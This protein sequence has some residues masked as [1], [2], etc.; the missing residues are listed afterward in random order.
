MFLIKFL[1]VYTTDSQIYPLL[2]NFRLGKERF[3]SYLGRKIPKY[4]SDEDT[5]E[6]KLFDKK[7][8]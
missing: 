1:N 7:M 6:I 5:F 3:F 8:Y 2:K 4:V